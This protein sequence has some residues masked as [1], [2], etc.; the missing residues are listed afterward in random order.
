MGYSTTYTIETKSK[1]LNFD[2]TVELVK[3]E[4]EAEGLSPELKKL[5]MAGIN[6]RRNGAKLDAKSVI[7]E[8]VG[9]N[10]F[11]E[12]CK[13]YEHDSNMRTVSKRYPETL[14][15]LKGEGEESGDIW[16]K[17][18]M[19]GKVQHCEARIVFEDFDENKLV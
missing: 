2:E 9:Y 10:P 13:W 8:V 5:A 4:K 18:Y 15:V 7:A 19:N 12:S 11:E 17:Y 6:Q 14:F 1:P 3:L 16:I